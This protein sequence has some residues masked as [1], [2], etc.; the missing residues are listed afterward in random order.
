MKRWQIFYRPKG[1][2]D[3]AERGG[4]YV[5]SRTDGIEIIRELEDRLQGHHFDYRV[6]QV[7][8][9]E[10]DILHNV[11]ETKKGWTSQGSFNLD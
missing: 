2:E 3:R 11:K 5:Q 10:D 6:A 4:I 8:T 9:T 7:D 1:A